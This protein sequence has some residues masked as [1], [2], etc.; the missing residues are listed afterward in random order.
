M[1]TQNESKNGNLSKRL[2]PQ[3]LIF[4]SLKY[5]PGSKKEFHTIKLCLIVSYQ[6]QEIYLNKRKIFP[7]WYRFIQNRLWEE[8][9]FFLIFEVQ[10]I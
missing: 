8:F 3:A 5:L 10:N 1:A 7:P 6:K 2:L 4:I 9:F